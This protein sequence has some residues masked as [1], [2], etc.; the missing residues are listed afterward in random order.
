MD[1]IKSQ[2]KCLNEAW[3]V[4]AQINLK[5]DFLSKISKKSSTRPLYIEKLILPTY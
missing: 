5:I 1:Q 3:L 4:R 2:W